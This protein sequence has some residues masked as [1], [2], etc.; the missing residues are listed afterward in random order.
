MHLKM[1]HNYCV[2]EKLLVYFFAAVKMQIFSKILWRNFN[3][4]CLT[5]I[6]VNNIFEIIRILMAA[7]NFL[8]KFLDTHL[9]PDY[10]TSAKAS[11][12]DA[13]SNQPY[14]QCIFKK[15]QTVGTFHNFCSIFL[16]YSSNSNL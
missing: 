4:K 10:F 7:K 11:L 8:K 12:T 13:P 15:I 2:S 9:G 6:R 1:C 14:F 5:P 16:Q 3:N